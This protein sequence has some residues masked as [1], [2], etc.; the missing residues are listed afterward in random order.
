MGRYDNFS[1]DVGLLRWD[2]WSLL[3]R[4]NLVMGVD[5]ICYGGWFCDGNGPALLGRLICCDGGG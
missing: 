1:L 5:G 3:W 2:G 4:L